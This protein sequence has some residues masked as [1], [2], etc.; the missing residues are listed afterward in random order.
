[1]AASERLTLVGKLLALDET[2]NKST[3]ADKEFFVRTF[4]LD[5]STFVNGTL[6]TSSA[7]FQ[8][9]G[10]NCE[11]ADSLNIGDKIEVDFSVSG[12]TKEKPE[13]ETSA[14][15]PKGIV[16]YT[17]LNCYNVTVLEKANVPVK[18]NANPD[19]VAAAAPA[20]V[21]DLPF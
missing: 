2:K 10:K 16:C 4:V 13:T 17:N 14:K 1:M 21:D 7:G 18:D 5:T 19:A 3:K 8:F 9:T 11:R 6:Y 20:N 15:N 12:T